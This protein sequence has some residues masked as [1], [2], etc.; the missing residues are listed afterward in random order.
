MLRTFHVGLASFLPSPVKP[1]MLA[2]P[3]RCTLVIDSYV[4]SPFDDVS[5]TCSNALIVNV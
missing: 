1:G 3:F 4:T 2:V 5:G